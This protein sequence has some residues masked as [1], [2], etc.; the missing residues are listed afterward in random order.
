MM[1]RHSSRRSS[2]GPFHQA[3]TQTPR[4]LWVAVAL[5][6]VGFCLA[7]GAVIALRSSDTVA[8]GLFVGSAIGLAA[9][10]VLA[11]RDHIMRD[12]A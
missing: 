2:P 6:A 4:T 9:G 5:L 10:L 11:R 1:Q 7:G 3:L 8:I 12:V